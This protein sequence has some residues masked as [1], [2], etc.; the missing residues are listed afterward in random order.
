MKI[1]L[2]PTLSFHQLG[3]RNNQEDARYPDTDR[4][5]AGCRT[6]IVC[7]GVGGLDKGEVASH[8]VAEALGSYMQ[9][10]DLSQN[11]TNNDFALA[12]GHAFD[13]L[14]R[15]NTGAGAGMATTMTF[16]T[17]HAGGA[18]VAHIGDSRIYQ[19]RPGVGIVFHTYDHSL[20]NVLVRTGNLSPFDAIDHPQSNVITRCMG[21]PESGAH[22]PATCYNLTDVRR[23]DYFLL[24]SDGVLHCIT[25][26]GL[27]ELLGDDISDEQK[28]EQ[29]ASLS[30]E[31]SDNNTAML[32][33][34][35]D[36]LYDSIP[37]IHEDPT[38]LQIKEESS[39]TR[40]IDPE[41][42]RTQPIAVPDSTMAD[43]EAE[44]PQN[45]KSGIGTFFSKLFN[46]KN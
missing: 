10:I 41:A 9:G 36:V 31:S 17:F 37:D 5:A 12:L 26:E 44:Y 14:D 18:Y 39:K 24:C 1:I 45:G 23:G 25:D 40:L 30:S 28:I 8:T 13:A 21:G 32:I 3:Q 15:V 7:D 4:P 46:R 22:A 11:F 29:L 38:P 16:A 20:V 33:H 35:A 19:I 34:V 6:F 27:V 43:V 42:S 2:A